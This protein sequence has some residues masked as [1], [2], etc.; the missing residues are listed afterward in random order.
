MSV[1]AGRITRVV[2]AGEW[3]DVALGSFEI[4]EMEFT[5]DDGTPVHTPIDERAYH[6]YTANN[7][8]Y[9]GPLSSIDLFKLASM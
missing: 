6:F 8:E 3:Y 1:I 9:Y 4:L 7:D 2:I 5:E